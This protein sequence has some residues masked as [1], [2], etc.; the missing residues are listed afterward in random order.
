[1]SVRIP[2]VMFAKAGIQAVQIPW[3]PAKRAAGMTTGDDGY[4]IL[5]CCTKRRSYR[6]A[7]APTKWK[8]STLAGIVGSRFETQQPFQ[9]KVFDVLSRIQY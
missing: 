9:E 3:I 4:F 6:E 8:I 1:M 7:V 2:V 5:L